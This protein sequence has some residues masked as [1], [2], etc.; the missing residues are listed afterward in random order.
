MEGGS[1]DVEVL[2][3]EVVKMKE[4]YFEF[5]GVDGKMNLMKKQMEIEVVVQ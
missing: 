5:N 1:K 2:C 3:E 4:Y